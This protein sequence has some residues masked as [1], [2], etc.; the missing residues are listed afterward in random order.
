MVVEGG[1]FSASHFCSSSTFTSQT[2]TGM[3]EWRSRSRCPPEEKMGMGLWLVEWN[4]TAD[5]FR[6]QDRKEGTRDALGATVE[7]L[8][9]RWASRHL[10]QLETCGTAG[11]REKC[12]GVQCSPLNELLKKLT[13]EGAALRVLNECLTILFFTPFW[14]IST[15]LGTFF[16]PNLIF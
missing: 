13:T 11:G 3:A 9:G 10:W 12:L 14:S 8:R 2:L 7:L 5:S 16:W 15:N 6:Q 4:C 1:Q